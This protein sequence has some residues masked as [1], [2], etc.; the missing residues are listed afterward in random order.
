MTFFVVL[1]ILGLIVF[2]LFKIKKEFDN[3]SRGEIVEITSPQILK[4]IISSIISLIIGIIVISLIADSIVIVP[5]GYKGVVLKFGAVSPRILEEGLS[6]KTPWIEKV[7]LMS[8]QIRAYEVTAGAASKDLQDVTTHLTLNYTLKEDAVQTTYKLL[9]NNYEATIIAPAMQE[10]IKAAT[11]QFN[12]EELVTRRQEVRD[13]IVEILKERLT[14]HNIVIDAVSI[15]NFSF[16]KAFSNAIE[17]KQVAVQEAKKSENELQ[18]V[19][20]EMQQKI[21]QAKAEAEALRMQNQQVTPMVLELR[22]IEN[23]KLAIE[24]WNGSVPSTMFMS[25]DDKGSFFPI[26]NL[27][28]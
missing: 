13:K 19:K 2:T 9:R 11:A 20:F 23:Q 7:A 21:E 26:I 24:K 12:A 28:K 1:F 25:G 4:I 5:T 10:A 22:R 27:S 6:F 18:R 8:I 15:T 3:P 17:E 16:S 14:L